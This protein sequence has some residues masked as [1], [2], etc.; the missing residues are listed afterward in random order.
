MMTKFFTRNFRS[1]LLAALVGVCMA[2]LAPTAVAQD[3]QEARDNQKTRKAEALSK[4]VYE[5]LTEAQELADNQQFNQAIRVLDGLARDEGLSDYERAN[6]LNFYGFIY[7]N[8]GN[9]AKAVESYERLL[10]IPELEPQLRTQ[11]LYTLAQLYAV[12]ENF[13]KTIQLLKE[14]F[15]IANNPGPQAY[16]LLGQSYAQTEQYDLMIPQIEKA[17]EV[18]RE[19]DTEIR[20]EWWNLLYYGYYQQNNFAKVKD[21]LKILLAN[22]P[23]KNYW[24]ALA[25]V[26]SELGEEKNMLAAYDAAYTQNLLSSE[27]ELVTLA[28]LYLQGEIPYKAAKVLSEGMENG[29]IEE[30]GKNYRLLSQAWQLAQ[31]PDQAVPALQQAARLSDDGELNAR[32][33][34]AYLNL[35]RYEDCIQAGRQAL[36]KG[37]VREPNDVRIT[38]GMCQYNLDRYQDARQTFMVVRRDDEYQKIGSQWISVIDGEIQRLEQ[39]RQ[40]IAQNE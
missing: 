9:T 6:M 31:E 4:A 35:D 28:Q 38:I 25:G 40:A 16:V 21:I 10:S 23:K 32:L 13:P 19:R 37:G 30:T 27:S 8:Q 20:E 5:K 22:W 11:T 1:T 39:L 2:S 34:V 14:W 36:D 18:A 24:T 33:A 7:Y 15:Q 26:Y 17:I 3:D 12:Q 29:N